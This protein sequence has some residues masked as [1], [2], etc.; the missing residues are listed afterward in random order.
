MAAPRISKHVRDFVARY[1]PSVEH[2][3]TFI[4]LQRNS[5]RSWSASDL[6]A[7]LG[8]PQSTA[9][10]VLERVAMI[11]F[12]MSLWRITTARAGLSLLLF[13]LTWESM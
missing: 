13:G 5:T 7:E 4:V 1:L 6:S 8:I 9:E 11:N 2:L 3:E 12:V 10:D